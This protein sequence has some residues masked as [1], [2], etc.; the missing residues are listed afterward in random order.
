MTTYTGQNGVVTIES[1]TVAEVRSFSFEHTVETIDAS[2]MGDTYRGYRRG[3]MTGS[4]SMDLLFS[5][6]HETP[7]ID[8]MIAGTVVTITMFPAGN[9]GT[10]T[11]PSIAVEAYI[12]G[13]N[14]ESTMDD[15]V[16]ASV[17]FQLDGKADTPLTIT[18]MT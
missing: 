17:T 5:S 3:M 15:M 10:P 7:I 18:G 8:A 13:Y 6:T 4:G 1:A 16:T 14:M 11:P 2:V 12:T 9:T